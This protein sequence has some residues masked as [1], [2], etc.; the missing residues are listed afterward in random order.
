MKNS[1]AQVKANSVSLDSRVPAVIGVRPW[2]W[3]G[4]DNS[5]NM[6]HA[7]AARRMISQYREWDRPGEWTD[8][9]IEQ[10]RSE[11]SHLVFVTANLIRLGV[12]SDHPSMKELVTSLV[13]LTKNIERA[14]L[15][16]VVFGLG[17]QADLN[18]RSDL[19]VT[20]ETVRLLKVISDHSRK[21]AV[22]GSFTAETCVKLGIKNIEVVGC[23][24]IFWH[25]TPW[26]S[27]NLSEPD[28]DTPSKIAFNFTDALSEANLINEAMSR[29]HD[30]I[31]QQNDAE[32]DLKAQPLGATLAP[33]FKFNWAVEKAFMKGFINQQ[34]Y[35]RW[36]RDHFFQFRQP[37]AW[38]DHMRRYC[39]SYGTRLHGNMAALISGARALWIVHDTRTKE[40]CDHFRLPWVGLDEVRGGVSLEE[41][42]D[43]ADFSECFR[44]Y[45]D[46]YRV[47]FDYVDGAG[48]PHSLP[49][50][51]G[52]VSAAEHGGAAPRRLSA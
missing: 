47:L 37:E 49:T 16:L 20:S 48:L 38:F 52:V 40:L 29:G 44:V 33:P 26:F 45:P 15:P 41:L 42:V 39:F 21:V 11:H 23:Q 9:D 22:R 8:A 5:G 10:L 7:A 6:I 1:Q 2:S 35:E 4:D 25:R 31:G 28:L 17:S 34:Q 18:C 43:R 13:A 14:G 36:I 50:P 32:E 51:V 12:P 3:R 27:W 19:M 46:R 30:F 24:S